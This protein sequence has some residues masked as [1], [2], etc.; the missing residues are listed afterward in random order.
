MV[1][2]TPKGELYRK[3][4]SDEIKQAMQDVKERW[5]LAHP[6]EDKAPTDADFCIFVR[7][8]GHMTLLKSAYTK[9]S[10]TKKKLIERSYE[11]R[12]IPE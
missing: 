7:E 4:F 8:N 3:N 6:G 1:T 2:T 9:L 11:Y 10:K 5:S 12:Q